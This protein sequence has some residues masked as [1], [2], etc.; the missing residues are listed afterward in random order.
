MG[1]T[2]QR[3]TP[4]LI[5]AARPCR[6]ANG[7]RWFVDE[8]YVKVAGRWRYAY[9]AVDQ[10]GQVVDVNVS[11]RRDIPAARQFFSITLAPHGE[12][13]EVAT[14]L[15]Q[16]LETVIEE[17]IDDAFH[18]TERYRTIASS[19]TTVDSKRDVRPTRGLKTDRGASVVIRGHAFIQ[20][21]RRGHYELGVE[22]RTLHLRTAAA[23]DELAAVI[24]FKGTSAA[25]LSR[26]QS[27]QRNSASRTHHYRSQSLVFLW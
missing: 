16:A 25:D 13:D 26:L 15:A 12:P 6:H 23:F 22:A 17:F 19:A 9:R 24:R 27:R 14:D 5:D 1:A 21:L 20:N 8:T 18:N 2:Q 10:P 7:G 3:F 11:P 4:L